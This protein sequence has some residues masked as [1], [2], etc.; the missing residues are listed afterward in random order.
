MDHKESIIFKKHALKNS[1]LM[2]MLFN[3]LSHKNSVRYFLKSA[4]PLNH[5][6]ILSE[7]FLFNW[8]N[9]VSL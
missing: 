5:S 7:G 9:D 4:M 8:L 1:K 2:L 6:H 3:F